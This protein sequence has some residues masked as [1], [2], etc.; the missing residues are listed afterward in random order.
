M[1]VINSVTWVKTSPREVNKTDCCVVYIYICIE[2]MFVSYVYW[3]ILLVNLTDKWRLLEQKTADMEIYVTCGNLHIRA[4]Y[5]F[6]I[7]SCFEKVLN[8][9]FESLWI[10]MFDVMVITKYSQETTTGAGQFKGRGRQHLL[11]VK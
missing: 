6:W 9:H 3:T 4:L 1:K 7:D 10:H 2:Q 11:K 8:T 5:M